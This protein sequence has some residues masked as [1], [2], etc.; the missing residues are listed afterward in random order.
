MR[1]LANLP[2]DR[3]RVH[4]HYAANLHTGRALYKHR[5]RDFRL[6]GVHGRVAKELLT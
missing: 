3:M 6:T 4:D 2:R 5:G 1:C